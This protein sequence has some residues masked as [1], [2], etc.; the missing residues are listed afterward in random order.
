ML[1]TVQTL[2]QNLKM[3]N[4]ELKKE[5]KETKQKLQYRHVEIN[6]LRYTKKSLMKII[7]QL[8][9]RSS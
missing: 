3:E 7:Q 8:K 2:V 9:S 5:L 4:E 6:D 1:K